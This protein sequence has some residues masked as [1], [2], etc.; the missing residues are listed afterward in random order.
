MAA[1]VNYNALLK[2]SQ[3]KL[4]DSNVTVLLFNLLKRIFHYRLL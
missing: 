1:L 4:S 3:D 2:E